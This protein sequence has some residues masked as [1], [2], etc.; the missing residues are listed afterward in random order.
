M[1]LRL[2][3]FTDNIKIRSIERKLQV[4]NVKHLLQSVFAYSS[5]FHI[6]KIPFWSNKKEKKQPLQPQHA[7][8]S[9]HNLTLVAI[10]CTSLVV[11][12]QRYRSFYKN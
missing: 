10:K 11:N 2:M 5:I 4:P 8:I 9:S 12:Y 1:T 7:A 3:A 6:T